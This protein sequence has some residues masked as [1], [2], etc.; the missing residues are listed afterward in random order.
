MAATG[1]L[2]G[3]ASADKSVR[4]VTKRLMATLTFSNIGNIGQSGLHA[5]R[6][7]HW[8]KLAPHIPESPFGF[9]LSVP[10]EMVME[11]RNRAIWS[12]CL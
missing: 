12:Q 3:F 2:S 9:G 10:R 6:I 11:A 1:V 5:G 7:A 8:P 4:A